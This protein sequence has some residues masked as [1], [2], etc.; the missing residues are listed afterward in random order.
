MAGLD[1][2]VITIKDGKLMPE[3]DEKDLYISQGAG[4]EA[5]FNNLI[6]DRDMILEALSEDY[7]SGY[8]RPLYHL[9]N[10]FDRSQWDEDLCDYVKQPH[11]KVFH[12]SYQG[13]DFVTK[14]LICKYHKDFTKPIYLTNIH[15]IFETKFN[16]KGHWYHILQGHDVSLDTYY[17]KS[18]KDIINKRLKALCK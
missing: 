2:G 5:C 12:W 7:H 10:K 1:W 6:F 13:I 16:Y 18:V 8:N 17:H 11:I 3:T 15:K 9:A 4:G 14:E